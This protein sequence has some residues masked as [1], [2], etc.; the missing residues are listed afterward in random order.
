ERLTAADVAPRDRADEWQMPLDEIHRR[1]RNRIHAT[2][3]RL[4]TKKFK[5]LHTRNVAWV[6]HLSTDHDARSHR[7]P[8]ALRAHGRTAAEA[9]AV[10]AFAL[11][12]AL[13]AHADDT[14]PALPAAP[15]VADAAAAAVQQA[16]ANLNI[17]VRVGSPG[18]AGAVA[19]AIDATAQAA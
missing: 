14:L 11:G 9:I 17:S 10:S 3:M 19:Q 2:S 5:R 12:F 7:I 13:P 6:F 8:P 18:D 16:A 15:V 4:S 1:I